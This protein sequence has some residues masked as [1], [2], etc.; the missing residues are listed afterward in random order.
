MTQNVITVFTQPINTI[1]SSCHI[2]YSSLTSIVRRFAKVLSANWKYWLL[3]SS[4]STF[5]AHLF[6]KMDYFLLFCSSRACAA[7]EGSKTARKNQFCQTNV[8]GKLLKDD[9]NLAEN[10]FSMWLTQL[11]YNR[12]RRRTLL[13]T[14]KGGSA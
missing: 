5:L 14:Q 4:S 8:Q 7:T 1:N 10:T 2:H 3:F 6:G 13:F 9:P 12:S 11:Q